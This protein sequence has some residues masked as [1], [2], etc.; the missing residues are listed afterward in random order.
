M[1]YL[2]DNFTESR[3]GGRRITGEI[4]LFDAYM[5]VLLPL[6]VPLFAYLQYRSNHVNNNGTTHHIHTGHATAQS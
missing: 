6:P 4:P 3:T 5:S 2:L 1:F